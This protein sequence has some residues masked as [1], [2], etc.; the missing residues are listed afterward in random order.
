MDR[1]Q[2]LNLAGLSKADYAAAPSTLCK[3]CGHNSIANQ[4][5]QVCY[6]LSLRPQ[7][8]IKLS[9]IGCS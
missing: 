2:K 3:G 7:D 4:I 6:D 9:G 1:V 5:I 8:V